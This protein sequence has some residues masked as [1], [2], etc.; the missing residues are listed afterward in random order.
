LTDYASTKPTME[1]MFGKLIDL[2]LQDHKLLQIMIYAGNT[3]PNTEVSM[4]EM[5]LTTINA[6]KITLGALA[7]SY[8]LT[9]TMKIERM[10]WLIRHPE[11]F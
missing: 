2:Q 7:F 9:K 1:E 5:R 11:K 10:M 4:V 3:V 8:D 6:C